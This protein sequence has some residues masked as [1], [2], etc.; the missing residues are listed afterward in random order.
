MKKAGF[1]A[2]GICSLFLAA[3]GPQGGAPQSEVGYGSGSAQERSAE[4]PVGTRIDP[5]GRTDPYAET[6]TV[7]RN[8]EARKAA[9][10]N[11]LRE[12]DPQYRTIERAVMNEQHELGLVLNRSVAMDDIPK[13]MRAVLRQMAAQFPG[14]DLT[15]IAYAPSEPPIKI[16]TGR[17]DARSKEMTWTPSQPQRT[18]AEF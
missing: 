11:R 1:L 13:L 8:D 17:L 14:E 3:C 12:S 9:F 16:G 7:S 10:L 2:A 18:R 6:R 4:P 5:S 15:V